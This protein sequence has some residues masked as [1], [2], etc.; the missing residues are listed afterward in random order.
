[1]TNNPN[2]TG[3][4]LLAQDSEKSQ[5]LAATMSAISAEK[6]EMNQLLGRIQ[7]VQAIGG[8]LE[9][10]SLSQLQAIKEQK[11]YKQ[12]QGQTKAINGTT[13]DLGTWEGFCQGIGS[14]RRAVDEKLQSLQ[15][16]GETALE[17]AQNLGMTTRELRKLRKLDPSDQNV[18]IG[19]LEASIGDKDAIVEL[20]ENMSAKHTK[21]KEALQAKINEEKAEREASDKVIAGKDKKINELSKALAREE[22][23]SPYDKA[24]TYAEEISKLEVAMLAVFG[25]IDK[26][27]EHI[28]GNGEL[29]EILRVNQGQLLVA[30]KRHANGLLDKYQ[31]GDITQDDDQ[32]DW[33]AEAKKASAEDAP[34][35]VASQ[36]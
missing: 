11:T 10:L 3:E 30:L 6:L 18:I 34:A 33:V 7:A 19:E 4:Q 1:M 31:L 26:L 36:S 13:Y 29:P 14:S 23:A 27:F 16:L 20:I 24:L 9:A 35:Y 17:N 25:D 5:A 8:M 21:D 15:L 22:A 28:T 2:K 12:L 32:L